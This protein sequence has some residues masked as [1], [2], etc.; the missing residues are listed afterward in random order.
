[1][2]R[3]TYELGIVVNVR[4]PSRSVVVVV[5]TQLSDGTFL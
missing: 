2:K 1:M 3:Y 4:R 5:M